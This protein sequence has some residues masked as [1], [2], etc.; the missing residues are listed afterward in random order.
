M[1]GQEHAPFLRIRPPS[2]IRSGISNVS[3]LAQEMF[4]KVLND[5]GADGQKESARTLIKSRYDRIREELAAHPE[6]EDQF[7]ALPF[8]AGYFF[9]CNNCGTG[10]MPTLF[11]ALCAG[12]FPRE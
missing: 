2:L 7:R 6:Y 4:L 9:L 8:N 1:D 11:A 12:I 10:S 5:P 3:R